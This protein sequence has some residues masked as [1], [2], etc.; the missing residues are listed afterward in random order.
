M[1]KSQQSQKDES[2][3]LDDGSIAGDKKTIQR[4]PSCSRL[5]RKQPKKRKDS[6]ER[7]ASSKA[8]KK[9]TQIRQQER[10]AKATAMNLLYCSPLPSPYGSPQSSP[11]RLR[12]VLEGS[13]RTTLSRQLAACDFGTQPKSKRP[14]SAARKLNTDE[15]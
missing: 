5:E 4:K 14:A 1:E 3:K 2:E 11:R 10:K 6:R 7:S 8:G 12:R 13:P 9:R 15:D